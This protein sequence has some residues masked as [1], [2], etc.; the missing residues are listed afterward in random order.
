VR[1]QPHDPDTRLR[2][3][4]LRLTRGDFAGARADCAQLA[5]ARGA[6]ATAGFACLAEALAGSGELARGRLLLD[7]MATDSSRIDPAVRAYLFATRGELSERAGDLV[8]AIRAYRE[9]SRLAPE[10]DSIRAALADVLVEHGDPDAAEPLKVDN[11]SLALLVRDAALASSDRLALMNRAR[12]WLQ[13]EAERGDAIHHR[14]AALL[15]LASGQPA[16]ALI[17][18]RRNFETQRELADVRVLARAAMSARDQTAQDMLKQWL[19]ASGYEDALTHSIL[20][21]GARG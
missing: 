10:D 13:L 1:E 15:A 4:S 11:P 6:A 19:A 21:E 18:A 9:A 20:A 12:D 14:E 16:E 8:A 2:R 7:A 3:G 17:E 5:L